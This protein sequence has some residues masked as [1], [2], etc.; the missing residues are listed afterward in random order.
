MAKEKN[1]RNTTLTKFIVG[2]IIFA[3]FLIFMILG[4]ALP[5]SFIA[6]AQSLVGRTNYAGVDFVNILERIVG[7]IYYF[8]LFIGLEIL[9]RATIE[10]C[11]TKANKKVKTITKLIGSTIKYACSLVWL[12]M[13]MTIWGVDTTALL[14]SVGVIALIIGLGAQSLISDILAGI[15][16]VFENEYEVGDVV[17]ID[18]FRGTVEEIGLTLTKIVDVSGNRKNINNSKISTVINLSRE[19]SLAV[20]DFSIE[21]SE[22]LKKVE[23]I[24]EENKEEIKNQIPTLRQ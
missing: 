17:Y 16:I 14:V 13:S 10:V 15:N 5:G 8:C 18:G 4:L 3:I 22:D 24:F 21:Y 11:T 2:G 1:K 19:D 7:M 23:Q 20:V 6:N 9:L 12:F